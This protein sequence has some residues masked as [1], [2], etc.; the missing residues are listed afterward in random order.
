MKYNTYLEKIPFS[1][2]EDLESKIKQHARPDFIKLHQG[3][4]TFQTCADLNDWDSREF[5]LSHVHSSPRG[6][7]T[8]K[9]KI[10]EKLCAQGVTGVKPSQVII[11]CGASHAIGISLRLVLSPGDEVLVLA[12]Q[13]LF[14]IGLIASAGGVPVEVPVFLKL[15]ED[16]RTDFIS[17][18]ESS[19]S[20]KTRAI[21]F[22]TPNN[23]TGYSLS[24]QQL[25]LLSDFAKEHNLWII[26]DNA[27]ELYDFTD[28]GF[29][30]IATF[31]S[32]SERTF[33]VYTFSKTYA[34]PGYRVGY[35]VT[36]GHM[37]EKLEKYVLY[38]VYSIATA[39]QYGAYR[40]LHT[41]KKRLLLHRHNTMEAR[42]IVQRNLEI[43]ITPIDGGFYAFLDLTSWNHGDSAEF[44]NQ[45]IAEGVS[46]A[47]GRA[48]GK[49]GQGYARI[50][51]VAVGHNDLRI[52]IDRLNK[53]YQSA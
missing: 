36:P 9:G 4:T 41:P 17:L 25:S 18:L 7:E 11:T 8:L 26:A 42:N 21:Y 47:A 13:W 6:I 12:P 2:F 1:I 27:Y 39:S 22:N 32:A 34:M 45:A 37:V 24:H 15:S 31:P 49:Y 51:F 19:L 35:V 48:F 29:L 38:S 28:E 44:I 43:P 33:S 23:P 30:D 52:G 40:A 5:P 46:I 14:A 3:K 53:V 20:E 16:P 50:C 10:V